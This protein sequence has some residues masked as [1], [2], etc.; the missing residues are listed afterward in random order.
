ME[1]RNRDETVSSAFVPAQTQ[2]LVVD[3]GG[4]NPGRL[5]CRHFNCFGIFTKSLNKFS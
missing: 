1:G 5:Q 2:Y 4:K 3:N